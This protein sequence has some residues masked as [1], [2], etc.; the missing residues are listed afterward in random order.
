MST[1]AKQ[2]QSRQSLQADLEQP[3]LT[4][5]K[6]RKNMPKLVSCELILVTMQSQSSVRKH[7]GLSTYLQTETDSRDK[8]EKSNRKDYIMKNAIWRKKSRKNKIYKS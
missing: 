7:S 6:R 8:C 4:I 5:N 1:T 3:E 2:K